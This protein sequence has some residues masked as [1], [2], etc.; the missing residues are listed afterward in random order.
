MALKICVIAA[1]LHLLCLPNAVCILC[2]AEEAATVS[3]EIVTKIAH[4]SI[5]IVYTINESL[6]YIVHA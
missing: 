4:T 1:I 3:K 5:I 2:T 6:V